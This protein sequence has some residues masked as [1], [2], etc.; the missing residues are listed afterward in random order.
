M[1][2]I[3][4]RGVLVLTDHRFEACLPKII[5]ARKSILDTI[6]FHDNERAAIYEAPSLVWPTLEELKC[7]AKKLRGSRFYFNGWLGLEI[8]NICHSR[9]P[10]SLAFRKSSKQLGKHKFRSKTS[11]ICIYVNYNGFAVQ[12]VLAI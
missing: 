11:P 4:A 9:L 7:A 1:V 8:F 12:R 2:K 3:A 10:L 6:V 5:I